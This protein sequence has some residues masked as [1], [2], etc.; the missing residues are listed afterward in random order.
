M[1]LATEIKGDLLQTL[2]SFIATVGLFNGGDEIED[3]LY[4]RRPIEFGA[5][6][7]DVDPEGHDTGVRYV[8]NTNEV[9][10]GPMATDHRV[11]RFGLFNAAGRLVM[12]IALYR[13]R[14]PMPSHDVGA[15]KPGSI[16][17]GITS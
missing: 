15:F 7:T 13:P 8:V 16:K 4:E 17:L 12:L 10:F 3:A 5:T 1:V 14:D 6:Q 11:D 2:A 9:Q